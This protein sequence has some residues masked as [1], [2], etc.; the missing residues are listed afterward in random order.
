MMNERRFARDLSLIREAVH[1]QPGRNDLISPLA[2]RLCLG[3][4]ELAAA[5]EEIWTFEDFGPRI[6]RR[7]IEDLTFGD[8]A[9]AKIANGLWTI[10]SDPDPA[11]V[12]AAREAMDAH[13]GRVET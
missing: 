2:V 11:Y 6:S 9:C 7:I 1:G 4:I 10:G 8:R 13:V 5:P 3:L 12:Q